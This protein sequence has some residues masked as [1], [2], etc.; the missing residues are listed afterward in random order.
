MTT[1]YIDSESF[2]T[3]FLKNYDENGTMSN[4]FLADTFH[5]EINV[6]R[7]VQPKKSSF[8]DNLLEHSNRDA[9][10]KIK[11]IASKFEQFVYAD[12]AG[13]DSVKIEQKKNSE[14]FVLDVF[15]GSYQIPGINNFLDCTGPQSDTTI[16]QKFNLYNKDSPTYLYS[17]KFNCDELLFS[18]F[19][20][21][22]PERIAEGIKKEIVDDFEKKKTY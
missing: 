18:Y 7:K 13:N 9:H 15:S 2:R 11:T 6:L 20:K 4:Q 10:S 17:C 12:L 3:S 1:K 19:K 21:T 22:K 16:K 8:E 5:D 14:L